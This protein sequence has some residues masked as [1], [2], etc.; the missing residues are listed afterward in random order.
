MRAG[1][2]RAGDRAD[3]RRPRRRTLTLGWAL[4]AM[5]GALAG[6]LVAPSTF[7][8]PTAF[9]PILVFGFAAA[10]LGGLDSPLGPSSAACC[11]GCCSRT[12][13]AMRAR[14]S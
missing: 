9:D 5:V 7:V 11:S 3:P 10:V 2:V 1:G 6:L 4:A 13:P 12:S 8:S 14:R